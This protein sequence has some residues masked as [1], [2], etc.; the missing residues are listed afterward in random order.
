VVSSGRE[1]QDP[2]GW[3]SAGLGALL[4]ALLLGLIERAGGRGEGQ[5]SESEPATS[6]ASA[7]RPADGSVRCPAGTPCGTN[8]PH[9][10]QDIPTPLHVPLVDDRWAEE[11]L[12]EVAVG[13]RLPPVHGQPD[14]VGAQRPTRVVR[15]V[16]HAHTNSR[17]QFSMG[18]SYT[19]NWRSLHFERPVLVETTAWLGDIALRVL[20][21]RYF[22]P[23]GVSLSPPE[24]KGARRYR[25]P[26]AR[27][28]RHAIGCLTPSV[29]VPSPRGVQADRGGPVLW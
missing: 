16:L 12:H 3:E 7:P 1:P 23:G 8:R 19:G 20:R 6:W 13:A 22:G 15:S 25:G 11:G 24:M 28:V 10:V 21:C 2:T 18:G 4:L 14:R 27:R 26:A 17:G 29:A 5:W 9:S